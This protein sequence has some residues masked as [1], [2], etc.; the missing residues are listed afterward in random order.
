MKGNLEEARKMTD[1]KIDE[2]IKE[3]LPQTIDRAYEE[4]RQTSLYGGFIT[5]TCGELI[6]WEDVDLEVIG[7]AI[8]FAKKRYEQ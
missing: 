6:R 3:S 2:Q 5:N 1:I 7:K 8:E 4:F